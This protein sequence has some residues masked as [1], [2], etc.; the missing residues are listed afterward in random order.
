MS[1]RRNRDFLEKLY[2]AK[3]ILL[4]IFPFRFGRDSVN[5]SFKLFETVVV[6]NSAQT[7]AIGL[8]SPRSMRWSMSL[9]RGRLRVKAR[10]LSVL[11]LTGAFADVEEQSYGLPIGT[12]PHAACTGKYIE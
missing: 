9:K 2:A 5:Q 4:R 12:V 1:R 7:H 11:L 10:D 6:S 3:Q 8:A